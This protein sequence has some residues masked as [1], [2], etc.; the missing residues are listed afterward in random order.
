M[1]ILIDSYD[2]FTYNLVQQIAS[3]TREPIEVVRND[4]FEV[5]A[6]LARKPTAIVL[7][8]GPGVPSKAGRIVEL[9]QESGNVPLLGV[10]LGHQAIGEAFG[11]RVVRGTVPVHGKT[12]EI[13]HSGERLFEGCA[14][15]MRGTRYHSLVVER[16]TLPDELVVDAEC[17]GGEIMALSHRDR[18]VWGIQ[19]HCESFGT[20]GGDYLIRNFL[21]MSGIG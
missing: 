20:D 19:F 10:C 12:S 6:L 14:T 11:G 16:E 21:Q 13:S 3:L 9:V 1:L 17:A 18:P 7:S 2:S 15:P 8:P 4:A 5:S